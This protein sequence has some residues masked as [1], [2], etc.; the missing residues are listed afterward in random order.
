MLCAAVGREISGPLAR[1]ST[2]LDFSV[3]SA[4][5]RICGS[6]ALPLP[7]VALLAGGGGRRSHG[8]RLLD[9][10]DHRAV[11]PARSSALLYSTLHSWG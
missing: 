4:N 8:H 1:A 3:C 7:V 6:A 2:D 5:E 9:L 10:K 11:S